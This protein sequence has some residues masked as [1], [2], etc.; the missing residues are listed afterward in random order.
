[1]ESTIPKMRNAKKPGTNLRTVA[2]HARSLISGLSVELSSKLEWATKLSL[3][4]PTSFEISN[5]KGKS[6]IPTKINITPPI[7]FPITAS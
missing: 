1:M 5:T 6:K 4:P 7:I 3:I 2:P